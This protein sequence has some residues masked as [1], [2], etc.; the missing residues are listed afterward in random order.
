ME[1]E[2]RKLKNR[3]EAIRARIQEKK[4]LL[5]TSRR[6]AS[7]SQESALKQLEP[8]LKERLQKYT[9]VAEILTQSRRLL[10][11]ELVLVF[12]LRKVQRVH[13][14]TSSR[15]SNANMMAVLEKPERAN[16][17]TTAPV[18]L[19]SQHVSPTSSALNALIGATQSTLSTLSGGIITTPTS[20]S[21]PSNPATLGAEEVFEFRI[22][23]VGF[24]VY[25]NYY[26]YPR[27]KFNAAVGHI[28]H[29]TVLLSQY[30]GV[31]LPFQMINGGVRSFAQANHYE[32]IS[33]QTN[34]Q[35]PLWLTDTNIES[36]TVGLSMLNYNIAYLCFSQGVEIS[37]QQLP[38]TLENLVLCCQAPSL[39]CDV[40]RHSSPLSKWSQ[41]SLTYSALSTSD[42]SHTT[43]SG[44]IASPILGS[45]EPIQRPQQFHMD[46]GK[47]LQLHILLRNRPRPNPRSTAESLK[48]VFLH[49]AEVRRFIETANESPHGSEDE[50]V[51]ELLE[52]W[53]LIE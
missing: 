23:N 28:V 40:N 38:N 48:S 42:A 47:V 10:I 21:P 41:G 32:S 33:M 8:Q 20:E 15:S 39:G 49:D 50:G 51:D 3:I 11:R 27:E 13:S 29:M 53:H 35:V 12:R 26:G 34:I 31:H 30:L 52:E 22:L 37:L 6:E 25:G 16:G 44:S 18:P 7:A 46:F 1:I 36:F 2:N 19:A 43:Q 24:S 45:P 4:G 14:S 17:A 9:Q 5:R